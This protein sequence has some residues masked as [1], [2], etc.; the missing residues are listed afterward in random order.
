LDASGNLYGTTSGDGIN[1]LGN[2]FRLTSRQYAYTSLHD[3]TGR[4]DGGAPV[5]SVVVDATGN[6]YGTAS[7]GGTGS[8]CPGGCGVIWEITP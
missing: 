1:S 8:G 4:S 7:I 2:V 3:F 6:L 5:S